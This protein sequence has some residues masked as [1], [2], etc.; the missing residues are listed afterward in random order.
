MKVPS[1]APET[2]KKT[3]SALNTETELPVVVLV[4][5]GSASASEIVAGALKNN[6]RAVVAGQQTFGKGSVQVLYEI[7]RYKSALKLTV[8]SRSRGARSGPWSCISKRG[9]R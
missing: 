1:L 4:N 9:R 2:Q 6:G 5:G 3:A 7:R 8:N